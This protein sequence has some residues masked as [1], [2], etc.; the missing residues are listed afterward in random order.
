MS[1]LNIFIIT[2]HQTKEGTTLL[3]HVHLPSSYSSGAVTARMTVIIRVLT[4][5]LDSFAKIK[6]LQAILI[7]VWGLVPEH[8]GW[9]YPQFP[10]TWSPLSSVLVEHQGVGS[11]SMVVQKENFS[12]L[13]MK[14]KTQFW[15]VTV[16]QENLG[17]N[18]I[19]SAQVSSK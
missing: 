15:P 14:G 13:K 16:V 11:P 7:I 18:N 3:I 2:A 10:C 9:Q 17:Q 6:M 8:D 4:C 19:M 5:A 12:P 1:V